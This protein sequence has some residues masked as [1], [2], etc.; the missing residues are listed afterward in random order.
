MFKVL[1]VSSGNRN[2]I[3]PIIQAQ[4]NSLLQ[5]NVQVVFFTIQGKGLRGYLRNILPLRKHIKKTNPDVIHAHYS[6]SGMV[7]GFANCKKPLLVSLMGSDTKS[8]RFQS[9]LTRRF[10]HFFWDKVIVKSPGMQKDLKLKRCDIIPNGVDLTH[11]QPKE[12]SG[13]KEKHGFALS[14]QNVLFLANTMRESKNFPLAQKAFSKIK[15][16]VATLQV[17]HNVP[18]KEIP[19]VLSATDVVLLTSK[20]EGSPNVVK[21]A[22]AYNLPVVATNVGDVAWL[23]GNEPGHYLTSFESEDVAGKL[24]KALTFSKE[25]GRTNGRNRI[26]ELGLDSESVAKRLIGIYKSVLS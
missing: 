12:D 11:F 21:E 1:F 4:A 26:I 9:N 10:A 13:L 22:M 23:F 19:E 8:G 3:S 15:P 24:K 20:W 2:G 7:A 18:H 25:K 6:L 16:E 5:Q 17:R 14:G